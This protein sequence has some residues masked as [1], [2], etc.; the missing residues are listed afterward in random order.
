M[1]FSMDI[2]PTLWPMGIVFEVGLVTLIDG[3]RA[4]S[5]QLL[6]NEVTK[7]NYS[8]PNVCKLEKLFCGCEFPQCSDKVVNGEII[9]SVF[10]LVRVLVC[11]PN[12]QP[13][14]ITN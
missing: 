5:V 13:G 14:L 9:L 11:C 12:H 8:S 1:L 4:I 2:G 3:G 7:L 6:F 10:C